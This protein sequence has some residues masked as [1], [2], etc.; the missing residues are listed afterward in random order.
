[1]IFFDLK[2][3]EA[4]GEWGIVCEK[5]GIVGQDNSMEGAMDSFQAAI[6]LL[7]GNH[8]ADCDKSIFID[9]ER[10]R[11]SFK[12]TVEMLPLVFE[13]LKRRSGK[14]FTDLQKDLGLASTGAVHKY[15]SKTSSTVPNTEK[16]IDLMNAMNAEISIT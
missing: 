11:F 2:I 8:L 6:D 4:S 10:Q 12:N 13:L 9:V 1:M 16:F 5:L 14:S 15:F 3:S 7:A